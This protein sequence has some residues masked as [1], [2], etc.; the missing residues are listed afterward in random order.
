MN[1]SLLGD[2]LG[3][4][5]E[6]TLDVGVVEGSGEK[7]KSRSIISNETLG[8]THILPAYQQ[9]LYLRPGITNI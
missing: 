7:R 4:E 1:N 2:S 5:L 9:R 6:E 3:V 8:T